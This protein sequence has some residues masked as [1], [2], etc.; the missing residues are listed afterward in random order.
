MCWAVRVA[1]W[2]P[3]SGMGD[4]SVAG[5]WLASDCP[6]SVLQLT[7]R[8]GQAPHLT[9]DLKA[10]PGLLQCPLTPSSFTILH[11]CPAHS[12]PHEDNS[13]FCARN[14]HDVLLLSLQDEGRRPTV[15]ALRFQAQ[16]AGREC[17][18][19]LQVSC[20]PLRSE[21]LARGI[22]LPTLC[23]LNILN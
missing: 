9:I 5:V 19:L 16:H 10:R 4:P 15:C 18:A 17:A 22:P 20:V 3:R 7:C 14:G 12:G 23:R 1:I 8:A 6:S 11:M 13:M 2:M 21:R